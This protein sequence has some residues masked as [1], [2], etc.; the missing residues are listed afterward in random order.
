MIIIA[1]FR[2]V[3]STTQ[4][5]LHRNKH[6]PSNI[7]TLL[8]SF[9]KLISH[10]ATCPPSDSSLPAPH[11]SSSHPRSPL[12]NARHHHLWLTRSPTSPSALKFEM[13]GVDL[14]I[15]DMDQPSAI[16][17]HTL[18]TLLL[19]SRS[20]FPAAQVKVTIQRK[21][22]AKRSSTP[23]SKPVRSTS[24]TRL[25]RG[26]PS[27]RLLHF[28]SMDK[29]EKYVIKAAKEAGIGWTMLQSTVC[30]ENLMPGIRSR[31][32]FTGV[33]AYVSKQKAVACIATQDIGIVA[34]QVI[35]VSLTHPSA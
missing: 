22:R 10:P 8:T 14:I 5:A 21:S 19:S 34:A 12:P 35:Q 25:L 4:K 30:M 2:L 16:F 33:E 7:Y 13:S 3:P 11:A 27:R 24:F 1:Y 15:G 17:A 6:S 23:P 26:T 9:L 29:M 28:T 32:S 18:A 31:L 20:K